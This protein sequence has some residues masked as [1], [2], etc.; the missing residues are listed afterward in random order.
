MKAGQRMGFGI[1]YS[2]EVRESPDFED[3]QE[4]LVLCYVTVDS[5]IVFAHMMLQPPGGWYPS[6]ALHPYGTCSGKSEC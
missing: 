3:R 4:Q 5:E 6:V 2:P 1:Q